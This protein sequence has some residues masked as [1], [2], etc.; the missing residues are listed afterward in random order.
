MKASHRFTPCYKEPDTSDT[1]RPGCAPKSS[2]FMGMR[3]HRRV[4]H[5]DGCVIKIYWIENNKYLIWFISLC[6]TPL[7]T[8]LVCATVCVCIRVCAPLIIDFNWFRAVSTEVIEIQ[9]FLRARLPANVGSKL[10]LTIKLLKKNTTLLAAW[11]KEKKGRLVIK[12]KWYA[13]EI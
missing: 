11:S 12:F 8:A 7:C 4:C 13:W 1:P 2:A 10:L 5:P 6:D 9:R 3:C